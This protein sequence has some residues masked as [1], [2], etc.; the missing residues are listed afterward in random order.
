MTSEELELLIKRIRNGLSESA[1]LELKRQWWK[2]DNTK[3]KEEFSKDIA[4]M[5]NV[6]SSM[7]VDRM[8]IVGID[9]KGGLTDAPLPMDEAK[10][11]QHL[12]STIEPTPNV[13]FCVYPIDGNN[14]TVINIRPPFDCPYVTRSG[15][16]HTVYVRTGS[17]IT[18]ASRKNLDTLYRKAEP[19][20][21]LTIG[22]VEFGESAD[23]PPLH[24]GGQCVEVLELPASPY[25]D[26][27]AC[28]ED[29]KMTFAE[30]PVGKDAMH[31]QDRI[32]WSQY[33]EQYNNYI[34]EL[35][36]LDVFRR[37]Y[38]AQYWD[39]VRWCSIIAANNGGSPASDLKVEVS[40]PPWIAAF[41]RKPSTNDLPKAPRSK[42]MPNILDYMASVQNSVADGGDVEGMTLRS[43]VFLVHDTLKIERKELLHQHH[44]R[45]DTRVALVALPG[46]P[47]GEHQISYQL[48]HR[49]LERWTEGTLNL[50]VCPSQ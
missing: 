33:E 16:V 40:L 49:Q 30:R 13:H 12:S 32:E 1:E 31:N 44:S 48:F 2:F 34:A 6:L 10:L 14:I 47:L 27:Q 26:R 8:I 9:S 36:K 7:D 29:E 22:W 21:E 42:R 5:A 25:A 11:Q 28:I 39:D 37:W 18:T 45:V 41:C 19:R 17:R 4:A 20:A 15:E 50:R 35:G 38:A 43:D 46:A 3:S 24:E 23:L